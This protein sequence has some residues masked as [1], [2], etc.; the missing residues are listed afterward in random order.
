MTLMKAISG[1]ALLA[2]TA[3]LSIP[4]VAAQITAS[5]ISIRITGSATE[6][7]D[8]DDAQVAHLQAQAA[9]AATQAAEKSCG[10]PVTR[11]ADFEYEKHEI[12]CASFVQV[13]ATATFECHG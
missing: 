9:D 5:P 8:F 4:A 3:L 6:D 1:A 12:R 10:G 7:N 11:S 2:S 13:R